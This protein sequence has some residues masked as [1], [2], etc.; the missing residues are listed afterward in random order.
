MR[1]AITGNICSGKTTLAN[2]LSEHYN[3]KIYSFASNVKKYAT[4]IFDMKYKDR[5]LIQDFAEKLKEIDNDIWIKLLD[6]EIN[7]LDNIIIDDLR[8]QNE[9]DYLKSQNFFIIKIK[10]TKE[11]QIERIKKLYKDN[12][13]EHIDRLEHISELNN[14]KSDIEV[15][16]TSTI[17]N[18]TNII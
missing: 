17:V 5:K 11:E 10:I 1:I 4:E 18:F 15:T 14:L 3:L 13:Q 6:K 2:K 12:Y 7:G 9:L 16:D 8:F